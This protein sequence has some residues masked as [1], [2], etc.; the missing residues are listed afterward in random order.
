MLHINDLTYRIEGRVL[1]DGATT[2]IPS[3]HKVGV[4]GR[5]G[6]G[7]TTLL[8]L[9]SGEISPDDGEIRAPKNTRIVHVAQEAPSTPTSLIDE[10]LK[11]DTERSSLLEEAE[12][13]TDSNRI[14]E[15]QIRLTDIDAYSAPARAAGILAGLGFSESDQ[16]RGCREYSGGWRMRVSLAAALF[17]EPEVLLLDEPNNYL[18][19]EGT[20][21]LE[22]F[23]RNYRNTV[24]IV[25]HDRDLLNNAVNGIV[26]L[27]QH[28]LTYYSGGYDQFEDIRREKQS[29]ELKL[30]KKQDEERRRLEAFVERFKAKATK[31]AQA[32]SRVKALAR[33]KPIAAQIDDDVVPFHFPE[34]EKQLG[35][36]LIRL[37]EV[38]T[39]YSAEK[40]ILRN[41]NMRID[42]D[43]RIGL[44]G[45]NGNGKSTFAKLI[46]GRL[47][48]L[49][50]H[51]RQS[52]KLLIGYYTQHQIDDLN[53]KLSPY[54]YIVELL[55]DATEAQKRAKL[56][57][58]GFGVEKADTPSGQLSGGEKAR[59][60]FALCSFHKPH[61]L[62][63]DEPTNHLDVD[64]CEALIHAINSYDG[65]IILI[66]HD[67][68][69][70][71]ACTDR[72]WIARNQTV[73]PYDGDI[74][75]YRAECLA[76]R[77]K[78]KQQKN[79]EKSKNS[80]TPTRQEQRKS[81][82]LKRAELAPLK[83]VADKLERQVEAM[84]ER[85]SKLDE[86]LS[87]GDLYETDQD[88][89]VA[90]SKERGVLAK[91]IEACEEDWL[92][93]LEAY[94]VAKAE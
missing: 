85:L 55:E 20:L 56:G 92:Q 34:P 65:A 84:S 18:D 21:W 75:S 46:A 43:D 74:E 15:I 32:Q 24:I 81:A 67:R 59:L 49:S 16:K 40:P 4:V 9:I 57:Q 23:L 22:N 58:L 29:L 38:F 72:L 31:A 83:K 52:K 36:P 2:A 19:L 79:G 61:L 5:N 60:L 37:E 28:K 17:T 26:H 90:L 77:N 93:A 66:S 10:V 11:A 87:S 6:T 80:I 33:M 27:K 13:A 53:P 91:Q 71:Q 48:P 25:S 76:D 89:F 51:K 30:K 86:K 68:H 14:S 3:G 44:L 70:M 35:N 50:G 41:L 62:I 69:L 1:L 12:H 73:L 82:A 45:A 39:G 63:L 88:K 64:S 47:D 78:S 7:K 94:E 42:N 54:D 8:R